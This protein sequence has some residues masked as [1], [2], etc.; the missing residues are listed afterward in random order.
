MRN[1]A[2]ACGFLLLGL[3]AFALQG[4]LGIGGPSTS[5]VTTGSSGKQV[6]VVQD[7]F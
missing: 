4:C 7:A 2:R 3:F 6:N 5:Q 1:K